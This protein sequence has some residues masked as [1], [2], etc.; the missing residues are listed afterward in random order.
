MKLLRKRFGYIFTGHCKRSRM[1]ME[2]RGRVFKTKSGS[3]CQPWDL[4]IPHAHSYTSQ[5]FPNAGLMKN[6]CRNPDSDP[7]GPWCFMNSAIKRW[8]HCNIKLCGKV[9]HF[10]HKL[11]RRS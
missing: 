10:L 1:G 11:Y 4:Q 7:D 5:W 2:Y 8:E 9:Q 6:Y 3:T